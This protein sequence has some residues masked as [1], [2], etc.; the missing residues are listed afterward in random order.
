MLG[1]RPGVPVTDS[2]HDFIHRLVDSHPWLRPAL[3]QHLDACGGLLPHVLMGDITRIAVAL[4]LMGVDRKDAREELRRLLMSFSWAFT[5]DDWDVVNLIAVSFLEN[6]PCPH[7][8][9]AGI[10]DALPP[11]LAHTLKDLR[12]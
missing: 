6:L 11:I 3:D 7:E 4:H 9:G 8:K 12:G 10:V 1:C 2:T 5:H